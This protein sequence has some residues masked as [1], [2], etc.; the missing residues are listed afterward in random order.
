MAS[1]KAVKGLADFRNRHDKSV[2]IPAKIKAGLESLTPDGWEYESE[3][4]RQITVSTT[5]G[6]KYRDG[7]ADFIVTVNAGKKRI[8]CG[9]KKLA[10]KMREAVQS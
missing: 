6:A 4:W 5:D 3:F 10:T 2:I 9:S 1:K 8:Y 7:F